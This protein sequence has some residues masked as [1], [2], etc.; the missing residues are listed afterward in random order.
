M[1]K[2]TIRFKVDKLIRN[3]TSE[4]LTKK[5]IV[6]FERV[7]ELDEY[8]Q[9]LKNKLV[10][11]TEEAL[12]ATNKE[13]LRSELADVLEVIHALSTASGFSYQDVE[14]A[15]LEKKE[16]RGG[17][18]ARLYCSAIELDSDNKYIDDYRSRP[19]RYPEEK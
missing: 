17:F 3:K 11:E 1:I 16:T 6:I 19:D 10:E 9:K 13:E 5:N 18:D 12:E 15:R 2:K 4:R 8:I 14:H 7:M